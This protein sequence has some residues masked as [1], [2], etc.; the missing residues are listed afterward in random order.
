LV[1]ANY[2]LNAGSGYCLPCSVY[3]IPGCCN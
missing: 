2:Y 1:N 3:P